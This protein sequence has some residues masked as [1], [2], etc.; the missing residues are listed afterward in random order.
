MVSL[1]LAGANFGHTGTGEIYEPQPPADGAIYQQPCVFANVTN[2]INVNSPTYGGADNFTVSASAEVRS[3]TF[4][5]IFTDASHPFDI[6]VDIYEDNGGAMG[7]HFWGETVPA[8]YQT[9][10]FPT[11]PA[12]DYWLAM[13]VQNPPQPAGWLVSDPAF[14]PN[15]MQLNAGVWS[16]VSYDGMFGLYDHGAALTRS[17][18]AS[19]KSTF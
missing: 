3:I 14:P 15:M 16:T 18:W 10:T 13:S 1:A 17:T 9:E 19:I 8:A 7:T 2:A 4:W 6:A 12:G 5:T 11:L